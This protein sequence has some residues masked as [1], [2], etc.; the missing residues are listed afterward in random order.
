MRI[1]VDTQIFIWM[2]TEP[3]RLHPS[4][5][6]IMR[7]APLLLSMASPW[8]MMIK[9]AIGKLHINAAPDIVVEEHIRRGIITML[10]IELRHI[11]MLRILPQHHRDPFDRIII[12]QAITESIPVVSSDAVFDGY[13]VRRIWE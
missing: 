5:I 10:P 1:L 9:Y 12:A 3:K 6:K 13:G 4:I 7:Q 8:E 11:A 2:F